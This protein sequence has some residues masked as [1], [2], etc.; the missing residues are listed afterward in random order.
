MIVITW[1]GSA[2]AVTGDNCEVSSAAEFPSGE[3][4]D[5]T[6]SDVGGVETIDWT[7]DAPDMLFEV[8]GTAR[9]IR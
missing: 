4:I 5:S 7:H 9:E 6:F 8:T 2:V 3:V 1:S